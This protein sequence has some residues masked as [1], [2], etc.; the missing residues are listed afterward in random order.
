MLFLLG[1]SFSHAGNRKNEPFI[2]H[3]QNEAQ[4]YHRQNEQHM[5]NHQN[6]T[7]GHNRHKET[8]G[9]DRHKETP[10]FNRQKSNGSSSII[11]NGPQNGINR[12]ADNRPQLYADEKRLL[13]RIEDDKKL[14]CKKFAFR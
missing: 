7:P 3:Q 4:K 6:E 10:G 1:C 13:E 12:A 2:Q 8:P 5:N 11:R 9:F 14:R